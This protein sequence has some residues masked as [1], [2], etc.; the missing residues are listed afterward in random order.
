MSGSGSEV[1]VPVDDPSLGQ[2]RSDDL[3]ERLQVLNGFDID[4][5][6]DQTQLTNRLRDA[7]PSVSP[8][9]EQAL[10]P[11]ERPPGAIMSWPMPNFAA[12]IGQLVEATGQ[13]EAYC[14]SD[15]VP[16]DPGG[17]PV[18]GQVAVTALLEQ[19]GLDR[20]GMAPGPPARCDRQ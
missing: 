11:V 12:D 2:P 5:A 18:T 4:L 10:S 16:G 15:P 8:A 3:P 14:R 19:V 1:H 9:L 6:A 20:R 7:L 13:L 17:I